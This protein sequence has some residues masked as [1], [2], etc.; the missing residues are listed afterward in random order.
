MKGD[1]V[2][3]V[4]SFSP[5]IVPLGEDTNTGTVHSPYTEAARTIEEVQM[6]MKNGHCSPPEG[7]L[8]VPNASEEAS[9]NR[10]PRLAMYA[11]GNLIEGVHTHCHG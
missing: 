8:V 4:T 9:L 5:G 11:K 1:H 2:L 3:L 6:T 7:L 10:P